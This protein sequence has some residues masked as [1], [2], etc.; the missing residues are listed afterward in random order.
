MKIRSHVTLA[1]FAALAAAWLNPARA[2]IVISSEPGGLATL[3][4]QPGS[5]GLPANPAKWFSVEG[6]DSLYTCWS[7]NQI[8]YSAELPES[9]E[10]YRMGVTA[11]NIHGPL[12]AS[13]SSFKV[14]VLVNGVST[15]ML[16]IP[17]SDSQWNTAWM[18]LGRRAGPTRVVFTW[19]NDSY[20]RGVYDANFNIGA[21]Q[22][23]GRAVPTPGTGS[24][25]ALAFVVFAARARRRAF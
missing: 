19:T 12:A 21:V 3:A 5:A 8:A 25:A 24:L 11:R 13:Y 6:G 17:A 16:S 15:G 23:A 18:D 10:E 2:G 1:A 20:Q 7:G 22:F 14:S 4:S 9:E